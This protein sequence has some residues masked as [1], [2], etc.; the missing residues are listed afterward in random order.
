[1]VKR[2]RFE[3]E[4]KNLFETHGYG[5]TIWSPMSQGILSGK[6]ND[7]VAPESSRF[8]EGGSGDNKVWT[9]FFSEENHPKTVAM[10]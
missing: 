1:M 10:L 5:T 8:A 9:K 6:Y 2:D 3:T 4:Y 7:G